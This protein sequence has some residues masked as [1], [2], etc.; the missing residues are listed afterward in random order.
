LIKTI[1]QDILGIDELVSYDPKEKC[2]KA[3]SLTKETITNIG[4]SQ[5]DFPDFNVGDTIEVG[6]TISEGSKTRVQKFSGDV[7][8]FHKNGNGTTFTVR[9][10]GAN[11]I[12]VE[13]ILPYYS[14]ILKS[15]K[16]AKRGDVRRAKLFYVRDRIG[17]AARIAEKVLTK[18]QKEALREKENK[19]QNK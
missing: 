19:A 16:I 5:R 10:I 7:I 4:V 15:I 13:R 3:R 8:A 18:Q 14:P 9:R 11:G 6:I 1:N 12:G 17:K 2:M